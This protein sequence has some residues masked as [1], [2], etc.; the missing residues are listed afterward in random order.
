MLILRV[1][2]LDGAAPGQP[3]EAR[4]DAAG[5]T[6][7]RAD[8]NQ[9]VLPDPTRHISRVHARVVF[10]DGG[11]DLVDEGANAI[12]VNGAPVGPGQKAR[13]RHGDQLRIGGY[14][15]SVSLDLPRKAPAP[16]ARDPFAAF[17]DP[18]SLDP[19]GLG[20]VRAAVPQ[21]VPEARRPG[22]SVGIPDDFD[23]F[24]APTSTPVPP[25]ASALPN[26][27]DLGLGG[28]GG[29]APSIDAMFGLGP[30]PGGDPFAEGPLSK[31]VPVADARAP[32]SLDP[33]EALG[34]P[35]PSVP[36]APVPDRVPE[37]HG[38]FRVP[39]A[40]PEPQRPARAAI[41]GDTFL[42]WEDAPA[43]AAPG[44]PP[45]GEVA[46]EAKQASGVTRIEPVS[47]PSL[48]DSGP[49]PVAAPATPPAAAQAFAAKPAPTAADPLA[50][51]F[52]AGLGVDRLPLATL[53]PEAM[54]LVGRLLR[55]ATQGT[56]DLL[57]A[58]AMTK[59]EV[60]AEA[61]MIVGKD[62]NPLKFSPGV[63]AALA[64]LLQPQGR[65][66]MPPVEA[67]RE[68]YDD[69]R[70]H[71]FGFMAGLRAALAG[72]LKR[73]DPAVLE[74][75]LVARSVLDSVL[76]MNRRAKLWD[77]YEQLYREIAAEAEDDFH[78]LFGREFLRAYE[79]Q[80]A[81]LDATRDAPAPP[82]KPR[83]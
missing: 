56:L 80:V 59:R 61:T 27:L 35:S 7:G 14:L 15:V 82:P 22:A 13:L 10:A 26:E 37:V 32:A 73:F 43:A 17:G 30:T 71:Q 28:P 34:V 53:N 81:R 9:L 11:F 76:P 25:A 66:F 24:A 19:L 3:I 83:P 65:G 23:P 5:G 70:S 69:L 74:Q 75:R 38:T 42:S 36:A 77:L 55:E 16:A 2:S 39:Q 68:A 58:R 72:V 45:G 52:F 12:D 47:L 29:T 18:S 8:D 78:T 46:R 60:R 48:A 21:T 40:R 44:S 20:S 6:I 64:H 54:E 50:R 49:S 4:F 67:M 1:T 33:L 57:M 31:P 63:D 62:N 79:E 51:A 41:Q